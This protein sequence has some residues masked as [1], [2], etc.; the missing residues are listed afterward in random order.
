MKTRPKA[1]AAASRTAGRAVAAKTDT[2][3]NLASKDDNNNAIITDQMVG[4]CPTKELEAVF[5]TGRAG[6]A[7]IG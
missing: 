7:L 3:L 4:D 2:S 6:P 5:E 1:T